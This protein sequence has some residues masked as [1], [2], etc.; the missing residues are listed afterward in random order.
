MKR[1]TEKT[2]I[3]Y[4]QWKL[5]LTLYIKKLRAARPTYSGVVYLWLCEVLLHSALF[6]G[7][8]A[9]AYSSSSS[10]MS[11]P[12]SSSS[13]IESILKFRWLVRVGLR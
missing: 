12:S 3:A 6:A 8:D 11:S 9:E 5:P 4:V 10:T 1:D 13:G 2:E 7:L